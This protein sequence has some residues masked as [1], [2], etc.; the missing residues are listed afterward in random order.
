MRER[1]VNRPANSGRSQDGKELRYHE[2]T[3]EIRNL[4]E[5]KSLLTPLI[6]SISVDMDLILNYLR[7]TLVLI[8]DKCR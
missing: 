6:I 8:S 5:I 1:G 7:V 3:K 2:K 4:R